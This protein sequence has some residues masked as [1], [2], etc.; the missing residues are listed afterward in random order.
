MIHVGE[1]VHSGR[2]STLTL[3]GKSVLL[4]VDK[5]TETRGIPRL[6]T[7]LS[8]PPL[9]RSSVHFLRGDHSA[10]G[11]RLLLST[12]TEYLVSNL[13]HRDFEQLVRGGF[14]RIGAAE[15]VHSDQNLG[16][17]AQEFDRNFNLDDTGIAYTAVPNGSEGV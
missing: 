11:F 2:A 9:K 6:R 15:F 14:S 10:C 5:R 8:R 4:R 13:P 12:R 16:Q 3:L 1:Y 7:I 17:S